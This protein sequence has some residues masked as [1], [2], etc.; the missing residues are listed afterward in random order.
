MSAPQT[1]LASTRV[2]PNFATRWP[3]ALGAL[4]WFAVAIAGIWLFPVSTR[5]P[6]SGLTSFRVALTVFQIL[7]CLYYFVFLTAALRQKVLVV[8]RFP[9]Q[10]FAWLAPSLIAVFLGGLSTLATSFFAKLG[11]LLIAGLLCLVLPFVLVAGAVITFLPLMQVIRPIWWLCS[12]PPSKYFTVVEPAAA[13]PEAPVTVQDQPAPAQ[14]ATIPAPAPAKHSADTGPYE[15]EWRSP[16]T[17]FGSLTGMAAL[18]AELMTAIEPFRHYATGGPV[19]DRNGILLSG[20]PGNGKTAFAMAIA[21]ELGLRFVKLSGVDISSKWINESATVLKSLFI[22][23][24]GQPCVVFLDEFDSIAKDRSNGHM[25]EEDKKL[26]TALLTVLD[27]ARLQHIVVVAATNY[28]DLLDKAA[29]RE[30][31]FDY[32]IEVP[33]PDMEA[34]VGILTGMLAKYQVSAAPKTI[35]HVAALW[36]RRSVAFIES[37]VKRLR[38]VDNRDKRLPATVHDFKQASRAA[39]RRAGNIPST[40]AK[41]S[42][43]ALTG[44]VRRETTSLLYRLRN[45][46]TIAEQG[47]EPPSGVLLYGPPGT[48]KT[49]LVRALAR[50]LEYWHVFEVNATEVLHDPRKFTDTVHLAADHRPAIVF[51]DEA[52]ELLR[53]RNNS[54]SAGATN[55]ILK[56]MDG[57]MGKV[58]EVLFMAATNNEDAI[59]AAALRGGRFAEKI[60]MGKLAGDDL[61]VFLTRE[62]EKKRQVRFEPDVTPQSVAM[63]LVEVAPADAL[64]ILRKAINY[65]FDSQTLAQPVNMGHIDAAI[66]SSDSRFM[67]A[68]RGA[69]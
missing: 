54:T 16:R 2:D 58:P 47:G 44:S 28:V 23:A 6:H 4:A 20:P 37:T 65:T 9:I 66:Q 22:Q 67:R 55:E 31:R 5:P 56:C 1:A 3:L 24:A 39:T 48:G 26:V 33:Y 8:L 69:E 68:S 57:M 52:D 19:A 29:I 10:V 45:W 35:E 30:G 53:D 18:K 63:R 42:E 40:G 12:C 7:M 46:E 27:E 43:L 13:T 62:F 61:V 64:S 59:D 51:I 60:F 50:E 11:L 38:D 17:D 41:L 14:P 25:H 34:R 21:G 36:E 49:N 15:F 32:R